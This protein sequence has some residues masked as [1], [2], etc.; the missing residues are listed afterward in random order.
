MDDLGWT[1]SEPDDAVIEFDVEGAITEFS[2]AAERLFGIRRDDAVGG[3]VAMLVPTRLWNRYEAAV[4]RWLAT[5][6]ERIVGKRVALS[7]Q[8]PDGAMIPVE[9]T[10]AASHREPGRPCL[11][12]IVRSLT[13]SRRAEES[14]ALYEHALSQVQFGIV[15]WNIGTR[16]ITSVNPAYAAL[17][18]YTPDEIVGTTGEQLIAPCSQPEV[19][20]I[21]LAM[22]DRGHFTFGLQLRRKDGTT[23]PVL[24]SSSNIASPSGT[25]LRVTTV[26]DVSERDQHE[27]ERAAAVQALERSAARLAA[28]SGAAHE[29]A[30]G[31]G[32]LDPLLDLVARR[33]AEIVGDGCVVRLISLDGEWIE[34]SAS[35]YHPD[36]EVRG[37]VLGLL[38]N[39][40]QRLGEGLSGRVAASG[41]AMIIPVVDPLDS[42][43]PLGF[44]QI[45]AQIDVA[46]ALAVPLRSRGR[47]VGVVTVVRGRHGD[48]YTIDDQ[49]YAQDLADRAGLAID[50]AVLVATLEQQ[51]AE[52]TAALEVANRELEAFSYSA[53]HDLRTPL[54]AIE[55]FSQLLLDEYQG[56]IAGEGLDYLH[57]I[58]AATQRMAVLIDDLL[59][60]SRIARVSLNVAVQD[61]TAIAAEVVADLGKRHPD[62]RVSVHLAPGLSARADERLLRILLENLL[63]NA[64]KFT[65]KHDPAQIWFGCERGAFYVRDTGAGFDMA[66]SSKLFT[67]FERLHSLTDYDGTGI[68]LAIVQR[69]VAHH[70]GR[71][72]A[73]AEVGKGAAF[74]FTL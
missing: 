20:A 33:I 56:Q 55:G 3:S 13:Q 15:V 40:R 29:F 39:A 10:V 23:V 11:V 43:V 59:K 38:G 14:V 25:A 57:R 52:R 32:N 48:P 9:V 67:P 37:R 49:L 18:G 35:F 27:R 19:P 44:Q 34:P 74:F 46:S 22:R 60:L 31:S 72:W 5:H 69:I 24:A 12:A 66:Y 61:L 6:I 53:S 42:V 58:R 26:I 4:R 36:S 28:L 17:V 47:T 62:R 51:V 71:I 7:A 8:R 65:A 50:N 16:T 63:G 30:V 73:N 41:V 70:G 68:G 64:W 21:S 2:P 45:R 1:S 54:R